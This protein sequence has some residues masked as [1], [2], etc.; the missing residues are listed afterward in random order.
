MSTQ[1]IVIEEYL[2]RTYDDRGLIKALKD[3]VWYI[4]LGKG[5]TVHYVKFV[6]MT[7][8]LV[9]LKDLTMIGKRSKPYLHEQ[10]FLIERP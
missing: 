5:S 6:K 3:D 10:I 1:E 2:Y 7:K 8:R 4:N 9:W